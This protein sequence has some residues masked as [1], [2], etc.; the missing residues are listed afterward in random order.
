MSI[1]L[2]QRK[3]CLCER[4][5]CCGIVL[6]HMW[7]EWYAIC[8]ENTWSSTRAEDHKIL[9]QNVECTLNTH[10]ILTSEDLEK[11][12][13]KANTMKSESLRCFLHECCAQLNDA[14][15]ANDL[16]NRTLTCSTHFRAD[17]ST[18]STEARN[19]ATRTRHQKPWQ[20]QHA[21]R[22][23]RLYLHCPMFALDELVASL[24]VAI[25]CCQ[26][27]SRQ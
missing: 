7:I 18:E 22:W 21:K 19:N 10:A 27:S 1:S 8:H 14:S 26:R 11:F 4:G 6:H 23:I 2:A 17:A 3:N 16:T 20:L 24:I 12:R 5:S 15:S 13:G 25:N 9:K